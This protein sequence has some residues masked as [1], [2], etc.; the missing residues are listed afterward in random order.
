MESTSSGLCAHFGFSKFV[1]NDPMYKKAKLYEKPKH[2]QQNKRPKPVDT[3]EGSVSLGGGYDG[4]E[5]DDDDGYEAKPPEPKAY[6]PPAYETSGPTPAQ[7]YPTPKQ[8][9]VPTPYGTKAYSDPMESIVET[10]SVSKYTPAPYPTPY[11]TAY[12]PDQVNKDRNNSCPNYFFFTD[13]S[14]DTC[15]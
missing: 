7:A 4:D 10:S 11:A 13:L 12:V 14:C 1:T 5:G 9:P 2:G 6:E 3:S 15:S 8:Y